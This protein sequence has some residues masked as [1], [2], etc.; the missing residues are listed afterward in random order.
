MHRLQHTVCNIVPFSSG[1]AIRFEF[2]PYLYSLWFV[3]LGIY[4]YLPILCSRVLCL[5]VSS[6][7]SMGCLS[8]CCNLRRFECNNY[9]VYVQECGSAE[10]KCCVFDNNVRVS[11]LGS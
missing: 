1:S 4:V 10:T 3:H 2:V 7:T 6:C 11:K 5:S 9:N 8:A